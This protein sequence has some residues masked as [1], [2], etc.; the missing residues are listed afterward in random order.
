MET[1][2][3]QESKLWETLESCVLYLVLSSSSLLASCCVNPVF[4]PGYLIQVFWET[5]VNKWCSEHESRI[6]C[7]NLD[8]KLVK[9]ESLIRKK[10]SVVE[11]E[12]RRINWFSEIEISSSKFEV[13]KF[14]GKYNFNLWRITM[15]ALMIHQWTFVALDQNV[16]TPTANKK[17]LADILSKAHFKPWR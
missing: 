1:S 12:G 16:H 17:I 14:N 11:E 10:E 13:E 5:N 15:N 4:V 2:I 8:K 6:T 9:E 3:Y 7:L